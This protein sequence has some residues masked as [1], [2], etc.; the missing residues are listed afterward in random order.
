LNLSEENSSEYIPFVAI[1]KIE[2]TNKRN[3]KY[4]GL[5]VGLA[6][7]AIITA[8]AIKSMQNITYEMSF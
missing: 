6:I 8:V 4:I 5:G 3:A 1:R 2:S 7:D